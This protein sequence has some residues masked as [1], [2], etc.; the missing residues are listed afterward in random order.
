MKLSTKPFWLGLPGIDEAQPHAAFDRPLI[1]RPAGQLR[2]VVQDELGGPSALRRQPLQDGNDA[3]AGQRDVD[4]DRQRLA[5]EE[6]EHA[7]QPDTA[8]R[9]RA[10]R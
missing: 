5:G 7:Q 1:E 9:R 8:A 3:G 6:I 2:A 10:R 4:L